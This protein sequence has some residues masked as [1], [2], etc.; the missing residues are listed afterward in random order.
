MSYRSPR[1]VARTLAIAAAMASIPLFTQPLIAANNRTE[2][3]PEVLDALDS[4]DATIENLA[5]GAINRGNRNSLNKQAQSARDAYESGKACP[6]VNKLDAMLAHT[7]ALREGKGVEVAEAVFAAAYAT[8]HAIVTTVSPEAKCSEL[9]SGASAQVQ[10]LVSTNTQYSA[11]IQ[12]AAPAL[13]T[14]VEGN[15]TWTEMEL[16]GIDNRVGP[17][18]HPAI[19][20]WHGLVAIPMGADAAIHVSA[21]SRGET[22]SINLYPFQASPVDQEVLSEAPDPEFFANPP[23]NKDEQAYATG[24]FYPES[25][26]QFTPLGQMRDLAIGQVRCSAGQYNPATDEYVSFERIE[27]DIE[28]KGGEGNFLTTQSLSPFETVNDDIQSRVLNAEILENHIGAIDLSALQCKGEE[29]LILT[30][31]DFREAAN[32]LATWKVTKGISTTVINV[33]GNSS[34]ATADDIDDLIEYRY[35]ECKVRPSYVLLLGDSEFIPPARTDYDVNDD[36]TTGSDWGYSVYPQFIFDIFPDFA[37]GRIPVDT[38]EEA[39]RVVDKSIQYESQPPFSSPFNNI[40][41][42]STAGLAAQFQ[43]CRNGDPSGRTQRSYIETAEIARN[44]L[45]AGGKNAERIY[46]ST[47]TANTTPNRY[48]NGNL[49]P[50]DLRSG[51]GFPWNGDTDDIVDAINEGRFLMM[52]R[53]HGWEGGWVNPSFTNSDL[54]SLDNGELLPV[55]YSVNCKSGYFDSETDI[56]SA[57]ESIMERLLMLDGGGMVG[58]LG[59]VRNSPTWENSALTRGFFDATWPDL[60]PEFGGKDSIT[61]LG[62]ILNHGKLYL[63]SQFGVTQTAGDIEISKVVDEWIMWHVFGD[64]TL[65]MWTSNPHILVL[66]IEHFVLETE[67]GLTVDYAVEGATITALELS[68]EGWVPIARSTVVNGRAELPYF[69]EPSARKQIMLSASKPGSVAVTLGDAQPDLVISE[70]SLPSTTLVAGQALP[71]A[72][73]LRVENIGDALAPGTVNADGSSKDGDGYVVDLVLS[74]DEL[75]PAGYASVPQPGGQAYEEDGLLQGGRLSRTVDV[76]SGASQEYPIPEPVFSDLGGIVPSQAIGE[77]FLCARID[78]GDVV[79]EINEDNNV[80]CVAVSVS[81]PIA[82]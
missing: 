46:V 22:F 61:R 36:S 50:A 60:A 70:I 34:Y 65:E 66:P 11:S 9:A 73:A 82:N 55:V 12:F 80:T 81:P 32:D 63:L 14:V 67:V 26:C 29:L 69:I 38:L 35:D 24:G 16:P 6:A 39:Q 43:C 13:W 49:L 71:D 45:L 30:H 10:T 79:A 42:Y 52:H 72:F 40:P 54:A 75:V 28:F 56:N 78:A 51:S 19:P 62:D 76:E 53:D 23:F 5:E 8:R 44:A 17:V 25:P 68:K 57:S 2:T 4:L 64:P 77:L 47:G 21:V 7:Q 27:F 41:F 37:V 15:E 59:D 33:G 58:G 3:A 18:G 74:S 48:Y 1:Y 20:T 31:P